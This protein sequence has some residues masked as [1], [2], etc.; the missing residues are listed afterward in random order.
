MYKTGIYIAGLGQSFVQE[1]VEKYATRFKNELSYTTTG[2]S[3]EVK[4]EKINYS[5][6][7]VSSVVSIIE[8]KEGK[9]K[10]VYKF[11]EFNYR[12]ILIQK[13]NGYNILFK[14]FFLFILV[15]KKF[16]MLLRR[17]FVNDSYN[18]T[19]QTFYVFTIFFIIS[20]AILFLIPSTFVFV[21][22]FATNLLDNKGTTNSLFDK[23][24]FGVILNYISNFSIM[25]IVPITTLLLLIVPESRTFVTTL[26]TEFACVDNYIEYGEQSQIIHG[27]LDLLIEYI[28][29]TE[30]D[31]KIHI[32]AYS[33]GSILA[34]DLLFPIGNMPSS[35]SKKL[36]EL[37][38]TIGTPYEFVKAYYPR[39]YDNRNLD[40]QDNLKWINVY[41]IS[42]AL[43][44]NFRKDA[45]IGNS[46]HGIKNATLK[47]I[48]INYEIAPV[49]P[50]S[51]INFLTL[52]HLKIHQH[53]WDVSTQGQSCMRMVHN[54]I[55]KG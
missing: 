18:R 39:F 38:V 29:E 14:N 2:T 11:Y 25:F 49:Q 6:N 48:N 42:D 44:T 9:E 32:H 23:T 33:F 10:I 54:E 17:L 31:S 51:I 7:K 8:K 27:N 35:N 34:L 15:V 22:Q 46:E 36:I 41:S 55:K 13:F 20:L 37:L 28:A 47:P 16:P 12:S 26:A 21:N 43:A 1:S 52:Y 3:Y 24:S 40:L 4:S 19:G 5:E 30:K 53:Y 50:F 45:V